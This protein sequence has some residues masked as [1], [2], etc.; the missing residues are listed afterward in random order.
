MGKETLS[1]VCGL[2]ARPISQKC[3]SRPEGRGLRH[4]T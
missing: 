3:K 4:V 2:T 1:L